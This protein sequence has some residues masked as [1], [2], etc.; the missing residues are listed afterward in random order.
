M[1]RRIYWFHK[2]AAF[3]ATQLNYK[4]YSVPLQ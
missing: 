2:Y 1:Y 3:T 4:Q